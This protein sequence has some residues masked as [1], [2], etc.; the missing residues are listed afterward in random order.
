[1]WQN[2]ETNKER[3]REREREREY[4]KVDNSLNSFFY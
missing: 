1:M 3:E 4:K 2:K